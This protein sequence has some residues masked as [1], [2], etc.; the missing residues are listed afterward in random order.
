MSANNQVLIRKVGSQWWGWYDSCVDNK[1]D[2]NQEPDWKALT[3]LGLIN[4]I[5]DYLSKEEMWL[6]Y[7]INQVISVIHKRQL[8]KELK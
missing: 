4:K 7:G 8:K 3:K 2:F 5:Q 1:F 6:E